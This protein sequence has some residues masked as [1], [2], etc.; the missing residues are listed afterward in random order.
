MPFRN[1]YPL[2]IQAG[3]NRSLSLYQ[4]GLLEDAKSLCTKV[5]ME[6]PT[7]VDALDLLGVI[8]LR[9][10]NY[11]NSLNQIKQALQLAPKDLALCQN[12]AL[13][14]TKLGLIEEARDVYSLIV[15]LDPKNANASIK[16]GNLELKLGSSLAA[17][18]AFT[19]ALSLDSRSIDANLGLGNALIAQEKYQQAIETFEHVLETMPDNQ[20]ALLQS[21]VCSEQMGLLDDAIEYYSRAI[22]TGPILAEVHNNL[23][24]VYARKKDF[25]AA[26]E[27]YDLANTIQP[28]FIQALLNK[29]IAYAAINNGPLAIQEFN[30]VLKLNP[31]N[32]EAFYNRAMVETSLGDF[33]AALN[34]YN[35]VLELDP[36]YVEAHW[37][38]A[39]LLLLL[40]NLQEGLPLYEWR[41]KRKKALQ[42]TPPRQFPHPRWTGTSDIASKKIFIHTEQGIGDTIQFC[43]YVPLLAA[44]GAHVIFECQEPLVELVRSIN[45][46]GEIFISG[47]K[48]LPDFDYYCPL[49]SLPLVFNTTIETVP[50]ATRYLSSSID[51]LQ[52]WNNRLRTKTKPRIGLAWRGNPRHDNDESRSL[53]LSVLMQYLGYDFEWVSLQREVHEDDAEILLRDNCPIKHFGGHLRD[54]SDTAAL[55]DLMDLVISVDTSVAHLSAALGRPTWILLPRIPDWRWLL[56]RETSPWYPTVKLYRQDSNREWG[57]ALTRVTDD[58]KSSSFLDLEGN[59]GK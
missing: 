35:R 23:G 49:M 31:D 58:L 8:E 30:S 22:K 37:N 52:L 46:I 6:M 25:I 40:G 53:S 55:C 20:E 18:E 16:L 27:H 17:V 5:L 39:L 28:A 15:Q 14:L 3:L 10:E 38:K 4:E 43:R 26:I 42:T 36:N 47:N 29:A 51:K 44:L 2:S 21:A 54:L 11:E 59:G 32:H 33:E 45:G 7:C 50:A 9:L 57:K 56:D 12:K 24:V 1:V 19:R 34:S 48:P 41:W 13:V